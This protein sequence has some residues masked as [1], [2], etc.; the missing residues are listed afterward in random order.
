[1]I[2]VDAELEDKSKEDIAKLANALHDG[3]VKEVKD[4]EEKLSQDPSFDGKQSSWVPI[5]LEK[6]CQRN[7][8]RRIIW[9][10]AVFYCV[11]DRRGD[12]HIDLHDSLYDGI[13]IQFSVIV[14][15]FIEF[16]VA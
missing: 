3:C 13:K 2:A 14:P 12:P 5:H 8:N 9:P 1:M 16:I 10:Y 15:V 4:Y 6:D 7:T 11:R